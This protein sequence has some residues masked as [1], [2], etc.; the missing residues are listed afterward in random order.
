MG[1]QGL[2]R[3]TV[4]R[5]AALATTALAAPFVRSAR[6]AEKVVP[7]GKM[8]L[9]WHTNIAAALARPAAA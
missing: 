4:L 9:A 1:T 5:T 3:R 6:A 8:A 7:T 2:T